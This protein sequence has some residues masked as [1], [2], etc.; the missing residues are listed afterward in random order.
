MCAM[1]APVAPVSILK[2]LKEKG[3]LGKYHLLLCHD[4]AEHPDDYHNI[5]NDLEDAFIILDNSTVELGAPVSTE[6]MLAAASV[7]KASCSVLPDKLA[8]AEFTIESARKYANIWYH[9]GLHPFMVVP[10]GKT[11]K[12][13][14][15]CADELYLIAEQVPGI[16]FWSVPKV[17]QEMTGSRQ[18]AI[19]YLAS[20][21]GGHVMYPSRN[22]H[23][24]GFSNDLLDDIACARR[25]EISGIDSAVPIRLGCQNNLL[26]IDNY[27]NLGKR[28][29]FFEN[30]PSLSHTAIA[31]I[32]R[33]RN[34]IG[35]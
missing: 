30:P 25:P 19:T 4:I 33:V 11:L 16:E 8:D 24:L 32:K 9:A 15:R 21:L 34:W 23:L 10:Q 35:G 7:V 20:L 28:G 2:E 6:T 14:M 12:E 22:I 17:L 18:Q 3:L 27:K 29:D 26:T 13:W 5:F 31:N 1:F